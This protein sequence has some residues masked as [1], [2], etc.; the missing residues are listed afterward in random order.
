MIHIFIVY[1]P[2]W[3]DLESTEHPLCWSGSQSKR[4][5]EREGESAVPYLHLGIPIWVNQALAEATHR[6]LGAGVQ[7]Q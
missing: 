7:V 4:T 3:K 6:S 2:I 5:P 1:R